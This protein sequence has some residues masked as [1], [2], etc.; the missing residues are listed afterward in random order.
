MFLDHVWIPFER[1][2]RPDDGLDPV[3]DAIERLRPLVTRGV[4]SLFQMAMNDVI[5][6]QIGTEL[7]RLKRRG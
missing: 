6:R 7:K 5:E 2:G 4:S 1:A 3:L